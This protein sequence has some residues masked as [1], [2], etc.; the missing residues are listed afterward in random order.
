MG[1]NKLEDSGMEEL[2]DG[3]RSPGCRIQI[4]RFF[5]CNL[6]AL[7]C[8]ALSSV[9]STSSYLQE[10][11]LSGNELGDL[12]V[13]RL[14]Q[15][16][17]HQDCK[18]RKLDISEGSLTGVCCEDL[19]LVLTVN[20]SLVE[21]IL[22]QNALSDSGVQQLCEGLKHENCTLR[23]IWLD[24]C[25]LTASCCPDVSS[26]LSTNRSLTELHLADNKL[27][28]SGV[29]QIFTGLKHP[30]CRIQK[31]WIWHCSMTDACCEDLASVLYASPSLTH[32][33]MC[34]NEIGDDGVRKICEGLKDPG[35][36]MQTVGIGSCSFT[37]ACCAEIASV[38]SINHS[39]TEVDL[40]DNMVGDAGVTQLCEGFKHPDCT[41]PRLRMWMCSITGACC[42]ALASV[43]GST[44]SLKELI[45]SYNALGDIGLKHLCEGLK[46]PNCRLEKL[47]LIHCSFTS[48]CSKDLAS[49]VSMNRSLLDLNLADNGLGDVAVR[50]LFDGLRQPSCSAQTQE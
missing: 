28:D 9:L 21:L 31:L 12:G 10:L 15:G 6:T 46:H 19:S 34:G 13:S 2:C 39:L 48:A 30:D 29:K 40:S 5:M 41:I 37:D 4:L 47:E 22:S 33:E 36:K 43:L 14:C 49:A 32:L 44:E 24:T 8:T 11:D 20:Q 42:A 25:S 23:T 50:S 38:L 35:C 17:K 7:S 27:G 1:I 26:V 18:L 45:L 16:L 3:L